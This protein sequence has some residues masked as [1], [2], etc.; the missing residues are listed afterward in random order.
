MARGL[1]TTEEVLLHSKT[2]LTSMEKPPVHNVRR[3]AAGEHCFAELRGGR[4]QWFNSLRLPYCRPTGRRYADLPG[5][6][7]CPD[8]NYAECSTISFGVTSSRSQRRQPCPLDD[9]CP[10]PRV[11]YLSPEASL[12]CSITPRPN[13]ESE[14]AF[15]RSSALPRS[16][17]VAS[18]YRVNKN[19]LARYEQCT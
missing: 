6:I 8:S 10:N 4:W 12:P 16:I 14:S 18:A 5:S 2:Y 11:S 19:A 15:L 9:F 7:M 1:S 13:E 17:D 3:S